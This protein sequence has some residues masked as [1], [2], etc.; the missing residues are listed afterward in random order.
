VNTLSGDELNEHGA[1]NRI[2][3]SQNRRKKRELAE[4]AQREE[5]LARREEAELERRED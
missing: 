3:K 2:M 4:L 5:E 1:F